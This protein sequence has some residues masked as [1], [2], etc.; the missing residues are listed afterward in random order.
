MEQQI[1][2]QNIALELKTVTNVY[3]VLAET[4][5]KRQKPGIFAMTHAPKLYDTFL[6]IKRSLLSALGA[7]K[8]QLF[9]FYFPR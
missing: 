6:P 7:R 1:P 4:H 5:F 2:T 3:H 8:S 9:R